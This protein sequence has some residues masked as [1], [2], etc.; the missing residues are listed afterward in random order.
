MV[1]FGLPI[2]CLGF[3]HLYLSGIL[4]FHFVFCPCL[5]LVSGQCWPHK[6]SLEEIAP[7]FWGEYEKDS[8]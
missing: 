6:V 8:C 1:E 7:V 5:I 3:L 4:A 2:F